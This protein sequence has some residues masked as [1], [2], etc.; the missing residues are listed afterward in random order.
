MI[1]SIPVN[2]RKGKDPGPRSVLCA[3]TYR[4]FGP[5]WGE[6]LFPLAPPALASQRQGPHPRVQMTDDKERHRSS[7]R[8]NLD[9]DSSHKGCMRWTWHRANDVQTMSEESPTPWFLIG[10]G[11]DLPTLP[12]IRAKRGYACLNDLGF[13]W[14][15]Q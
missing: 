4:I 5:A 3:K 6:R 11:T 7:E 8:Q 15:I 10:H 14:L 12:M 1:Q 2:V 13:S 9:S